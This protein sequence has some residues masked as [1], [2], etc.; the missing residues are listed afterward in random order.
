M[1]QRMAQELRPLPPLWSPQMEGC[2][3]DPAPAT[4]AISL[5]SSLFLPHTQIYTLAQSWNKDCDFGFH[6]SQ[7]KAY[8]YLSNILSLK[9]KTS[10]TKR[11]CPWWNSVKRMTK[12]KHL[13]LNTFISLLFSHSNPQVG[14]FTK[15]GRL[16]TIRAQDIQRLPP[17]DVKKG[18]KPNKWTSGN[19]N[20]TT[21][22]TLRGLSQPDRLFS[23]AALTGCCS[24]SV[25]AQ[26]LNAVTCGCSSTTENHERQQTIPYSQTGQCQKKDSHL[27]Y[28]RKAGSK[29]S[30]GQHYPD[31]L[32]PH[33]K[34]RGVY[35]IAN[36]HALTYLKS[37]LNPLHY[38]IQCKYYIR[39][40]DAVLFRKLQEK[41][42]HTFGADGILFFKDLLF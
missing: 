37:F 8:F 13:V 39:S 29:T 23:S 9:T 5:I 34:W 6:I 32:D 33:I 17:P 22:T 26:I 35:T 21:L 36:A 38:Q 20:K 1:Q 28:P 14:Y 40:C 10:E 2:A 3:P 19:N 25:L 12:Q 24:A 41:N 16:K 11:P 15:C 4:A 18:L 30:R 27:C 42:M 7:L 31:A